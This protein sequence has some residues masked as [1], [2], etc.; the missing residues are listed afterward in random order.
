VNIFDNLDSLRLDPAAA[1]SSTVEYLAHVPVRKFPPGLGS[2][3][4]EPPEHGNDQSASLWPGSEATCGKPPGR[5]LA[6]GS[7]GKRPSWA[8]AAE[9]DG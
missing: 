7:P 6:D 9:L 3:L 8:G 1:M 2:T 4:P 5:L